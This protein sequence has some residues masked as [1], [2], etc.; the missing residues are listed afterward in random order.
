MGYRSLDSVGA[1]R[2][3]RVGVG[4]RE[5]G[6]SLVRDE[7]ETTHSTFL[8]ISTFVFGLATYTYVASSAFHHWIMF[9]IFPF[10][11]S[12]KSCSQKGLVLCTL[13]LYFLPLHNHYLHY[14]LH[15]R[16]RLEQMSALEASENTNKV[17]TLPWK[18][19]VDSIDKNWQKRRS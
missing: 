7:M 17:A 6:E 12:R 15:V 8:E 16:R 18:L 9:P 2:W 4:H 14:R 10:V 13:L 11:F 3:G 19:S 1:R 5:V